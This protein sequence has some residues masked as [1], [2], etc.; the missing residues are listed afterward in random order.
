MEG[1]ECFGGGN[2]KV[3]RSRHIVMDACRSHLVQQSLS[4]DLLTPR[5]GDCEAWKHALYLCPILCLEMERATSYI[6]PARA[7]I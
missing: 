2:T 1:G 4:V 7:D 6:I 5:R 3:K